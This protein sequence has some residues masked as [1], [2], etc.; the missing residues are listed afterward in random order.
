MLMTTKQIIFDQMS[1]MRTSMRG[2]KDWVS[3][4]AINMAHEE[5]E[6]LTRDAKELERMIRDRL[7][8]RVDTW[9]S[10]ENR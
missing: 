5:A 4:D 6:R 1:E 8:T 2:I 10:A 7:P 3:V 9:H